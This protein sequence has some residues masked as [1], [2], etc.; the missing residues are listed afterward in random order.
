MQARRAA[1]SR[2]R[3]IE[4]RDQFTESRA[5]VVNES[6][7]AGSSNWYPWKGLELWI[8]GTSIFQ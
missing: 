4:S 5:R 6:G 7:E 1:T 8:Q 3:S 2:V